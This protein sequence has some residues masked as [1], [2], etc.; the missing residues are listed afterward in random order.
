MVKNVIILHKATREEQ[1]IPIRDFLNPKSSTFAGNSLKPSTINQAYKMLLNLIEGNIY[2][3]TEYAVKLAGIQY[4]W[5]W[6]Q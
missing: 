4:R 3:N 6:D 5:D 1:H 2:Q